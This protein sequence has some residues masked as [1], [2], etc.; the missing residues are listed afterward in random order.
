MSVAIMMSRQRDA[1]LAE[2]ARKVHLKSAAGFWDNIDTSGGPDACH[3][4]TGETKRNHSECEAAA[5]HYI[6]G[7]FEYEGCES[8][9]SHRVLL[10]ARY[11][12]QPPEDLDVVPLCGNHLCHNLRHLVIAPHGGRG[13]ARMN[14][15]VPV[16]EFFC[17]A[18]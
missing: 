17:E 4:W 18:A 2:E 15:A 11:G 12:K 1:R 6:H 16:Q 7:V 8:W 5:S 9:L 14:K 10:F 3:N 13:D